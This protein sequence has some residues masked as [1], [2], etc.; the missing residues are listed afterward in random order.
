M[1]RSHPVN[2][3]NPKFA[4]TFTVETAM[5]T[6]NRGLAASSLPTALSAALVIAGGAGGLLLS[7]GEAEARAQG[8]V[9]EVYRGQRKI[10]SNSCL[11][12]EICYYNSKTRGED[13]KT[14]YLW[15]TNAT[16]LVTYSN[17]RA[18]LVNGAPAE[19]R[20]V[21]GR[22]CALNTVTGNTFCYRSGR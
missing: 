2:H 21:N 20:N 3:G 7:T 9:C 4:V 8:G 14:E 22:T 10:D 16:T 1:P 12:R 6:F 15:P 17:G 19:P 11:A 18:R 13:C 5:R